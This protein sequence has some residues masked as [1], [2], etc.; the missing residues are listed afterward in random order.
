M[1]VTV[2]GAMLGVG[3]SLTTTA[4]PAQAGVA[5][6]TQA[7]DIEITVEAGGDGRMHEGERLSYD[8]TVHNAGDDAYADAVIVQM[9]P[10]G[11]TVVSVEPQGEREASAV[12]WVR[13]LPAGATQRLSVVA[14]AGRE[15]SPGGAS[16]AR[17]VVQ[18]DQIDIPAAGQF[19]S[20]VCVRQA[21][22]SMLGCAS[23]AAVLRKASDEGWSMA[24][25]MGVALAAFGALILGGLGAQI[26]WRRLA[27]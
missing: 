19:T 20:T 6:T 8:I 22:G 21:G 14:V 25:M 7:S 18:P 15:T 1:F 11:F 13:D 4:M 16:Q 3:T 5:D 9:L 17:S 23:D 24:F 27:H 12:R 10:A 26:A 2:L